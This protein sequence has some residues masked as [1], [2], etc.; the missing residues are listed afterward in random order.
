MHWL[1]LLLAIVFEVCG[2]TC[3]KLSQGFTRTTPSVLLFVFYGLCFVSLTYAMKKIELGIAYALWS[4]LGIVLITAVGHGYFGEPLN[5]MRLV[6]I[7]LILVG[8]VGL[9]L[10]M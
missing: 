4:G 7:G 3:M 9:N 2:T 8:V 5:T 1:L 6:C 10:T